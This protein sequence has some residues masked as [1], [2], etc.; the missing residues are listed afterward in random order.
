MTEN[1]IFSRTG[2]T[3][4]TTE[5]RRWR[6][7]RLH[8]ITQ[9]QMAEW[10]GT[11]RPTYLRFE[12]NLHRKAPR[13]MELEIRASEL[14]GIP[15]N[16]LHNIYY[17]RKMV[18]IRQSDMLSFDTARAL[19]DLIPPPP[20]LKDSFAYS[21]E[22]DSERRRKRRREN[23]WSDLWSREKGATSLPEWQKIELD[24][25][26]WAVIFEDIRQ[27]CRLSHKKS[28]TSPRR[29]DFRVFRAEILDAL[30]KGK[31]LPPVIESMWQRREIYKK[32]VTSRGNF[33]SEVKAA[34][35]EY[36]SRKSSKPLTVL[37]YNRLDRF[38]S[39]QK[40]ATEIGISQPRYSRIENRE[41][42]ATDAEKD[43][44]EQLFGISKDGLFWPWD[45]QET[46][47]YRRRTGEKNKPE[48]RR[49]EKIPWYVLRFR[50]LI[51]GLS[52]FRVLMMDTRGDV[53]ELLFRGR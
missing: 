33:E 38:W 51:M 21:M 26:E 28:V 41:C 43:K 13:D 3:R 23:Q 4:P 46:P 9:K 42:K 12:N 10:L 17:E 34:I 47:P 24:R 27:K 7:N 32:S 49:H 40:V 37:K 8:K 52:P 50:P 31:P 5:L 36:L 45:T 30:E 22:V 25:V 1:D 18:V 15:V 2:R 48:G 16:E 6:E 20:Y 29:L 39:Q 44:L 53:S 11:S 14:T 35:E 19:A